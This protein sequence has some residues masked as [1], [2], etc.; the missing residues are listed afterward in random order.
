KRY[1]HKVNYLMTFN[2]INVV[3]NAPF[4]GVGLVF[5]EGENKLN[6]MYQAA[7]HQFVA[8]ARAFKAGHEIIPD[9]NIGCM[10]AGTTT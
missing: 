2:E 1:Q 6:E 7:H 5:E 3:L 10:I 9:S 4:T 8:S